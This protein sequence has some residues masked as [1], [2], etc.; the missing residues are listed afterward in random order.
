VA[1]ATAANTGVDGVT[2]HHIVHAEVA[3][4][5]AEIREELRAK[6]CRPQPVKR[7]YIPK[8]NG[9]RAPRHPCDP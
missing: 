7:V 8:A 3:R 9:K 2:M 4:G 6:T 1:T 5:L